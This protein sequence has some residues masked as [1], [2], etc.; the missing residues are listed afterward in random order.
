MGL[1]PPKS[2]S[3]GLTAIEDSRKGIFDYLPITWQEK[4]TPLGIM[5]ESPVDVDTSSNESP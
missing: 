4:Q 3:W 5:L 1:N 2:N